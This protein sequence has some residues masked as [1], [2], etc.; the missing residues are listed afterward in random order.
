MAAVNRMA[1][2]GL[3]RWR[4]DFILTTHYNSER[5]DNI[6]RPARYT[7]PPY[8]HTPNQ[9]TRQI[10]P[11]TTNYPISRI[12]LSPCMWSAILSP[13]RF[14]ACICSPIFCS[15]FLL[16]IN[17]QSWWGFSI[18]LWINN[19]LAWDGGR[20]W[21]FDC[22]ANSLAKESLSLQSLVWVGLCSFLGANDS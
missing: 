20:Y 14:P 19:R 6:L 12:T 10:K 22:Y 4:I 16:L 9:T 13:P 8:L 2:G 21:C 17:C 3:G 18:I 7:L 1:I 11:P 5:N 15:T